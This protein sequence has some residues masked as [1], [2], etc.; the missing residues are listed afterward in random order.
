MSAES[1]ELDRRE[2]LLKEWEKHRIG[3]KP[4]TRSYLANARAQLRRQG[5][6]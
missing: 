3:R 6:L 2:A 5:K 1:D 4:T